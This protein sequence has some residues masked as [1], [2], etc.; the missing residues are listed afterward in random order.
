MRAFPEYKEH[1]TFQP[2]LNLQRLLSNNSDVHKNKHAVCEADLGYR[3]RLLE[4][5]HVH[6]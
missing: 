2:K 3:Y 4:Y 5:S 6:K 1:P